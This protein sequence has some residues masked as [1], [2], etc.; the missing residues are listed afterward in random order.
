MERCATCKFWVL[1]EDWELYD[2]IAPRD[3]DD[4]EMKKMPWEV[5]QCTCPKIIKFERTPIPDGAT[6]MDGSHYYAGLF[7]GPEFGCIHHSPI[8][9]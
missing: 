4:F 5:R 7:P 9:E 3:E 2:I 6:L 1:P 8:S